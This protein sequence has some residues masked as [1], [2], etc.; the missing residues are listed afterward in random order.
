MIFCRLE[1]AV[2][3]ADAL[4]DVLG[5]VA[6][7]LEVVGDA[8]RADD[9]AQVDGHRLAPGDRQDRAFF[10]LALQGVD[11]HVDGDR[12]LGQG[13]I[14]LAQ[15]IERV[16]DLFLRQSAHF[17]DQPGDI[18]QVDVEC[19]GGVFRHHLLLPRSV[20]CAGQ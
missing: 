19:L 6:D 16:A 1:I 5:E 2:D 15:R 17:G 13:G 11:L 10:D 18:L 8:Q 9:V 14:A 4:G 12:A 20:D 3:G 7:A